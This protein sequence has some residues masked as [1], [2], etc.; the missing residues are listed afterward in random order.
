M[1]T[2]TSTFQKQNIVNMK[3]GKFHCHELKN[4]SVN[5]EKQPYEVT[6]SNTMLFLWAFGQDQT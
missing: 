4:G 1:L 3:S 2:V 6:K 5:L